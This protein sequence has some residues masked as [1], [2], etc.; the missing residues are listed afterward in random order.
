MKILIISHNPISTT[1]NMGK[2]MDSLFKAF[3]QKEMVQ[4]YCYPSFPDVDRCDSYFRV[5]DVDIVKSFLPP[6][7]F[8]SSEVNKKDIQAGAK[9]LESDKYNKVYRA[10]QEYK[11]FFRDLIWKV[12]C[13]YDEKME[14]WVKKVKPDFI[15]AVV[16]NACFLY[17][18]IFKISDKFSIPIV[19][20]ICD[21]YYFIKKKDDFFG[22]LRYFFV[23]KK[24]EQLMKKVKK[25][26][27]ISE[28]LKNEYENHFGING[29]VIMTGSRAVKIQQK[30]EDKKIL[31]YM[32]NIRCNRYISI[33]ETGRIIDEINREN[34]TDY[35]L[36]VYSPEKDESILE[37]LKSAKSVKFK[38]FVSGEEFNRT[39]SQAELLFHT[40]AFDEENKDM[41]KHSVST[42]IADSL[43][44]GIPLVAYGP[45]EIS[46]MQHLIRNEC[47]YIATSKEQ[48]KE[49]LLK[50]FRGEDDEQIVKNALETAEKYHNSE[51]NSRRLREIFSNI[52]L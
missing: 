3:K 30:E 22:R 52:I 33:A 28:E 14:E 49:V 12:A 11:R 43:A 5:T 38:G 27:F 1:T 36:H 42:K 20:Y 21:D 24:I 35:Q 2:T 25:V 10:K 15:F 13:W 26:V 46:S 19:A 48:L 18:I 34:G 8:K 40:E 31:T 9:L 39:F 45:E 44:R 51:K 23:Q 37:T 17:D 7:E 41:V 50:A 6:F 4:L 47:A 29:D 32:G 16:G